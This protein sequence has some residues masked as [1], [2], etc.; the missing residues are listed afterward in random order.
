MKRRPIP[1]GTS[2][3]Q[4]KRSAIPKIADSKVSV[5]ALLLG[6]HNPGGIFQAG[7][8]SQ[9]VGAAANQKET[10]TLV[11][12]KRLLGTHL[13]QQTVGQLDIGKLLLHFAAPH[14][15]EEPSAAR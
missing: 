2:G 15:A 5:L 1:Q 12:A 9:A 14:L 8:E 4:T 10:K 3:D 6:D 13:V 7:G 11:L